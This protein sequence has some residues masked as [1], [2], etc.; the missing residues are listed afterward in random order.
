MVFY[1]FFVLLKMM[2]SET[3]KS[4]NSLAAWAWVALCSL[5]IFSVVPL[6][7]MIQDFVSSRWGRTAFGFAVLAGVA[8]AFL[9]MLYLLFFRL[10]IRSGPRYLWLTA[11]LG[12]YIYFTLKLWR[13][14]EE[15]AVH[16]LEYGVLGFLLFRALSITIRDK[17][18]YVTTFLAGSLVG[19][20]DEILQWLMPGRYWDSRDV[21]LNALAAGLIQVAIWKGIR[22]ALI[23]DKSGPRSLRRVSIYPS[24]SR[25]S[26]SGSAPQ[27]PRRARQSSWRGS[28]LSPRC[29]ARS[30]C[31]SSL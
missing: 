27:T 7:R 5:A 16:F 26:S 11:V 1:F 30:R 8:A 6:A 21:G 3:M 18:I 17:T 13:A 14:P 4:R 12:L 2:G 23:S 15:E 19:T 20:A 28:L 29:S 25:S 31:T 24:L 9:G 10:K 22:P